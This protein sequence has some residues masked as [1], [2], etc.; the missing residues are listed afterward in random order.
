MNIP[1]V[2][3]N[4]LWGRD[5]RGG[6]PVQRGVEVVHVVI[7][8]ALSRLSPYPKGSI[9][10]RRYTD[11]E[12]R[13]ERRLVKPTI[14][15]L[16]L[17]LLMVGGVCAVLSGCAARK[18][19]MHPPVPPVRQP[20]KPAL[21]GAEFIGNGYRIVFPVNG[22]RMWV[23]QAKSIR[24]NAD[25]QTLQLDG[26]ECWMYQ[27]G[28]EALHVTAR[29]GQAALQGATARVSL[30]GK[31]HATEST[32]HLS[33]EADR[34]RWT[35]ADGRITASNIRWRGFG[36]MHT[37]ENGSFSTDLTHMAFRGRVRTLFS[38]TREARSLQ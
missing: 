36:L 8:S 12:M 38:G 19:T 7:S 23:A 5:N 33:L 16:P 18:R 9:I 27:H 26:V 2:T 31:V 30:A 35:S 37:A 25:T 15:H 4:R 21:A 3:V 32:R 28:Q 1:C 6:R 13:K 22:P 20:A 17:F 11:P 14:R 34:F 29:T 10:R 24:A